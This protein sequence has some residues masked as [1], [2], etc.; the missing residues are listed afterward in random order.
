MNAEITRPGRGDLT[1]SGFV[2]AA[3]VALALVCAAYWLS[4]QQS[5]AAVW[6]SHTQEVLASIAR[7]RAALVDIQNGHR[8]FTISGREEDL[9]PYRA[10][11]AAISSETARLRELIAD[12][13]SQQ[14][15]L[16]D[17]EAALG[18]RLASAAQLIEARRSGGFPAAK[19]IVDTGLPDQEMARLR[20]ALQSL[21]GEEEQLLRAGLADHDRRLQ[22]FWTGMTALVAGLFA[23]L[24][25]LYLQ[26]RRRRAAQDALLVEMRERARLDGELQRLNRSLETQVRERTAA[27]SD[28]NSGLLDAKLRLHELSSQLI[29]AQEEERRHIARELHDDTGQSLSVIRMHLSDLQRG[30]AGAMAR[31]PDCIAIVDAAIARIRA[32]ALSLRPTMLDDLGL[33]DA[34]QWALEHPAKAAGWR[35]ALQAQELPAVLPA[36]VQTACFR[37]AQEALA[38]AARHAGATEVTLSLRMVG[39]DLELCVHDNGAGFDL[40]RYRSPQERKLHFGLMT[41]MERAALVGGILTV[42]TAPGS[43]TRIRASFPILVESVL[44]A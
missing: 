7:T 8:G 42:V 26:L 16:A 29:A 27:L 38:N 1:L 18:P 15:H 28:A 3:V 22:W 37:I 19:S 2:A 34:L 10:G 35:T 17:L 36:A 43:G 33:A 20:Q 44:D 23:V 11:R 40:E 41:M 39:S 13:P 24:A 12:N 32:M 6:V 30:G 21:E 14:Q 9:E 31:L 4:L 5:R 25:V